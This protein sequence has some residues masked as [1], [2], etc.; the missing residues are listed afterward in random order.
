MGND[1]SEAGQWW[2]YTLQLHVLRNRAWGK[3]LR[4]VE[5]LKS[6]RHFFKESQSHTIAKHDRTKFVWWQAYTKV[7]ENKVKGTAVTCSPLYNSIRALK[8]AATTVNNEQKVPSLENFWW[9]GLFQT[10]NPL[11]WFLCT[12]T[13]WPH[14]GT[15]KTT[16][17]QAAGQGFAENPT[18]QWPADAGRESIH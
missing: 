2:D 3:S 12:V 4:S 6:L 13:N 7:L 11:Y 5:P 16:V 8:T 1:G 14:S 18:A 10:Y 17:E 15:S 9:L